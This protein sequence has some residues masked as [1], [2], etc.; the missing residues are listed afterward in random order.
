MTNQPAVEKRKTRADATRNRERVLEAANAV[1]SQGGPGSSLEAVARLAG[2]G[3][4]TLYRHFPTREALSE[5]VSRR[6]VDKLVELARDLE[7]NT[8]PVQA[9]RGWLRANVEFIAP[10]KGMAADDC[11]RPEKRR[12]RQAREVSRDSRP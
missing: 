5:A 9:L 4:E 2:V 1:F 12:E 7:T 11:R 8:A 6:E 10:K 3:I